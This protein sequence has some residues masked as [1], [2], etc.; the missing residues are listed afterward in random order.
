MALIPVELEQE[1]SSQ[2]CQ[3]EQVPGIASDR[4]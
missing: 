3:Y 4:G 1:S 2:V